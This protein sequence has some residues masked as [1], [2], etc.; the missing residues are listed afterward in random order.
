ME[1][2]QNLY[3]PLHMITLLMAALFWE[4]TKEREM[5]EKRRERR[6]SELVQRTRM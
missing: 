4:T 1:M 2:V 5:K 6:E 3:R